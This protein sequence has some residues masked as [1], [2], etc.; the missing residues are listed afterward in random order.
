MS[1]VLQTII[2]FIIGFIVSTLMWSYIGYKKTK[3]TSD[4][5]KNIFKDINKKSD[6]LNKTIYNEEGEKEWMLKRKL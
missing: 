2:G 1:P 5:A 6:D 3:K 4:M